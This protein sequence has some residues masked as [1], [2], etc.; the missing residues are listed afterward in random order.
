MRNNMIKMLAVVLL[1]CLVGCADSKV[2]NGKTY[3]PYGLANKEREDPT[4]A[5]EIPALNFVAGF[6][7]SETIFVPAYIILFDLYEPVG[8]K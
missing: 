5:Y 3:Q 4:I 7:W 6:L 2:I 8:A 1:V